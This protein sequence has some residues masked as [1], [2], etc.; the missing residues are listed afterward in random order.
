[1]T[2]K[3]Q[4]TTTHLIVALVLFVAFILGAFYSEAGTT[5]AGNTTIT[6]VKTAGPATAI[7]VLAMEVFQ[8]TYLT[9][10]KPVYVLF[11]VD[12]CQ[13][14]VQARIELKK[15]PKKLRKRSKWAEVN[16]DNEPYIGQAL[17]ITAVPTHILFNGQLPVGGAVGVMPANKIEVHLRNFFK[18]KANGSASKGNTAF[19]RVKPFGVK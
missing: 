11:V 10:K 18:Q 19:D 14:C 15:L 12:K 13:P 9:G 2:E 5:Y 7:D 16:L 1:M 6:Q 8:S 4:N 3:E 17:G